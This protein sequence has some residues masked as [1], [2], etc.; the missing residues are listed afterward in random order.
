MRKEV[1]G[2]EATRKQGNLSLPK[3]GLASTCGGLSQGPRAPGW[4]R[5][6]HSQSVPPFVPRKRLPDWASPELCCRAETCG[7]A[8]TRGF[9]TQ[10]D[11]GPETPRATRE[12]SGV[13]FLR[14]DE[15]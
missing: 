14:Q 1:G 15:A 4:G 5:Q 2:D 13:P 8:K 3:R 12:A 6:H 10:L 11:E 7:S 9:H